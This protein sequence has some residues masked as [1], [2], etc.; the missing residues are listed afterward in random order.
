MKVY[1]WLYV[2]EYLDNCQDKSRA[3]IDMVMDEVDDMLSSQDFQG[4]HEVLKLAQQ[5]VT[6]DNVLLTLLTMT[7]SCEQVRYFDASENPYSGI[8]HKL[9]QIYTKL[10]MSGPEIEDTLRG[11]A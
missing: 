3:A 2:A 10:G 8:F 9:G 5:T 4:V 6:S 7:H 11:L 1:K